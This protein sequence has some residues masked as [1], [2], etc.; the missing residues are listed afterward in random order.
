[1]LVAMAHGLNSVL[2]RGPSVCQK[3]TATSP[4]SQDGGKSSIGSRRIFAPHFKLQ[5]LDSYRNDADCKGNQRATARKYGIHRRQIQKWLQCENNLR[6]S[7]VGKAVKGNDYGK[8]TPPAAA[9]GDAGAGPGRQRGDSA[10]AEEAAKAA[11]AGPPA[12]AIAVQATVAC[13]ERDRSSSHQIGLDLAPE[14]NPKVSGTYPFSTGFTYGHRE[15]QIPKNILMQMHQ[16]FRLLSII[17]HA[18]FFPE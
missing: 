7:V 11:V 5:V 2:R 3:A 10:G 13:G 1:M 8:C 14:P 4:H 12:V 9:L 18:A 16:S 17:V 15:Y 6:N